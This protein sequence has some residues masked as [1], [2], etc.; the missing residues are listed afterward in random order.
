MQPWS[1][2]THYASFDWA[3]DH[4]EAVIVNRSGKIVAD[5]QIEHT[6]QGW[7][8]WREQVAALGPGLAASVET[9]QGFVVDQLLESG[10][11]V[12]PI[13]TMSAKAYRQRKV[14]SGNKT[15][16]VDAWSLADALRV[17]GHGWKALA[18]EDP[19][20]A[21][22]RLLCRDEVALIEERTALINQL[23]S[24]LREYYPA[25]L[26]AFEDWTLPSA[27]AFLEAFPTPQALICGRSRNCSA[28]RISARPCAIPMSAMNRHGRRRKRS[29]TLWSENAA[30]GTTHP[31]HNNEYYC[32]LQPTSDR[33][34]RKCVN[35]RP[36]RWLQ[37]P[38][39][40]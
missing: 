8:H 28:T 38:F 31:A 19:L 20:V 6:A 21:E 9:S 34:L 5:F 33:R 18:K 22:L 16:H 13:S 3:H 39:A 11:A 29:V 40:R 10:V 30:A 27:W 1:K 32:N 14:P 4:H 35:S 15:D 12:Y 37:A 26:E 36:V 24:A 2:I 17:D 23:Q 7:Q 25:A